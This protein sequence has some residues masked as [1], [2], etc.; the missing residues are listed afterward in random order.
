MRTEGQVRHQLAQVRYRHLKRDLRTGLSR[1]PENCSHNVSV[2]DSTVRVNLCVLQEE[3]YQYTV[4]DSSCGGLERASKCQNFECANT[5][6]SIKQDFDEFLST[7]TRAEIAERYPDVAAL[8]WV[9][10]TTIQNSGSVDPVPLGTYRFRM[11]VPGPSL[12][13]TE[14]PALRNLEWSLTQDGDGV[15]LIRT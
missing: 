1:K 4:C 9:L 11:W 10:D 7:A 2:I 3:G 14:T 5:K 13:T 12:L 6:D 8:L 15:W